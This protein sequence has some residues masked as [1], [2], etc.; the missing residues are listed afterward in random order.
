MHM[1]M[2]MMRM[3]RGHAAEQ[4]EVK[5][6]FHGRDLYTTGALG[7]PFYLSFPRRTRYELA[8]QEKMW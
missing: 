6:F 8:E 1:M 5:E 7:R 4:G 3:R 2:V